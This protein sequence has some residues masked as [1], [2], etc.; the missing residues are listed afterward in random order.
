MKADPQVALGAQGVS[1]EPFQR[2]LVLRV[3][4]STAAKMKDKDR[5][6]PKPP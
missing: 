1:T 5:P 3:P 6:P 4:G 2:S